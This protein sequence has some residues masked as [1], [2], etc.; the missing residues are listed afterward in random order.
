[1]RE[2]SLSDYVRLERTQRAKSPSQ[3]KPKE[4]IKKVFKD[5]LDNKQVMQRY[6]IQ[7]PTIEER[8][9]RI[10]QSIQRIT[11]LMAEIKQ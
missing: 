6:N 7:Q 1:V 8:Q 3:T 10:K 11:K 2:E 9:E 5:S 4:G